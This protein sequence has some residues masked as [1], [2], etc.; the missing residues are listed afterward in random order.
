[1]NKKR[2]LRL[3]G[4]RF[5]EVELDD[6]LQVL[7]SRAWRSV[8]RVREPM[9]TVG[10]SGPASSETPS[11]SEGLIDMDW[12]RERRILMAGAG[13]VGSRNSLLLAPYGV[14]QVLIDHDVVELRNTMD[15]RTVFSKQDVG[16]LKVFAL[17]DKVVALGPGTSVIAHP[18]NVNNMSKAEL[19]HWARQCDIALVAIDEGRAILHLNEALY[20]ELTVFYQGLHRGGRSGQVIITRPGSPCLK[21]CMD[22]RGGNEIE[23]LHAER[24]LGIH[25]GAISQ[26]AVQLAVQELAARWG[27]P[28]GEPLQHHVSI[29]FVS[30]MRSQLTPQGPAIV[31]FRVEPDRS[32]DVCGGKQERR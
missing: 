22:V 6:P 23:T 25:F 27:S 32:C 19:R 5:T 24:A 11:P 7:V 29:L 26:L 1:V 28:L 9:S 14:T 15:G 18:R 31:S 2:K 16:K 13:A 10:S 3:A 12:M 8:G 20:P 30:N 4:G 21:C 17:R